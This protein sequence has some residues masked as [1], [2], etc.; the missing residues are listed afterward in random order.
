MINTCKSILTL[1]QYYN[2]CPN[3]GLLKGRSIDNVGFGGVFYCSQYSTE[4]E[5]LNSLIYLKSFF[6]GNGYIEYLKNPQKLIDDS[7]RQP[8]LKQ[9]GSFKSELSKIIQDLK[10]IFLDSVKYFFENF[11]ANSHIDNSGEQPLLKTNIDNPKMFHGLWLTNIQ[12]PRIISSELEN[13]L[14]QAK[15]LDGY[16]VYL[17]TNIS[18]DKLREMNS[19]LQEGNIVVK[20]I[21]DIQT[22]H[23]N[24]LNFV[25][26]P[27]EYINFKDSST[28]GLAIDVAK[29][30]IIESQGG[31]VA[32]LNFK[33]DN[34]FQQSS[35]EDYNF[36]AFSNQF[37]FIEN[38]FFV[39]TSHHPI[40]TETLN[41]IDEMI[42]SP[43]CSLQGLKEIIAS[44]TG[45]I[46]NLFSMMPI[47][48]GYMSYNNQEGNMDAL[49]PH[50]DRIY[51]NKH[52]VYL[53]D[54]EQM[55]QHKTQDPRLTIASLAE[56][57]NLS[58]AY[59]GKILRLNFVAP[60]IIKKIMD[61]EQPRGLKLQDFMDN[62]ISD[63]WEE[64]REMFAFD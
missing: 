12:N 64:Q 14:D 59:V 37:N 61:G 3:N 43:D 7:S 26:S 30:I 5:K 47:T 27:K 33:F 62:T 19:L 58:G 45:T 2:S 29:Y 51:G 4:S 1:E 49:T 36:I 55:Q 48:M 57:E 20:D 39:A 10:N 25:T 40:L 16:K 44:S 22:E 8:Q 32:D 53:L 31:I 13:F 15:K 54:V 42:N 63:L 17:W 18:P 28:T 35:I 60:D 50:I 34:N 6:E 9:S 11:E 41:I 46:A 23:I 52:Q 24:L 38:G 56:R 21:N